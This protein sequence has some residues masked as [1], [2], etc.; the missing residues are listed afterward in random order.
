MHAI[1][2]KKEGGAFKATTI[3]KECQMQKK[4][5]VSDIYVPGY[6]DAKTKPKF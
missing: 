5:F 3:K 1:L 2:F 4:K 6:F